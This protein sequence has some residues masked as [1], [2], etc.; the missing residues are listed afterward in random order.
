ME[1]NSSEK[2]KSQRKRDMRAVQA[3]GAELIRLSTE[4][5]LKVPLSETL[6][7]A[8]LEARGLARGAY[9]RQVR[10]IAKLLTHEDITAI[11]SAVEEFQE[12]QRTATA[13]FHRLERWRERL[14][15][16]GDAALQ[17]LGET[18]P[19]MDRQYVRQLVRNARQEQS[20]S[21][22][23]NAYR[24]LFRYLRDLDES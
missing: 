2:S 16:E 21:K 14:L 7:E 3:L 20:A 13:R 9:Q 10:H 6:K 11:R 18:F 24:A 15:E 19:G 1:Y 5:L 12:G 8:V 17:E 23:V 4:Q 22:A